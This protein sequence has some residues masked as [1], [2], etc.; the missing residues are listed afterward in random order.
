MKFTAKDL[1]KIF[2]KASTAVFAK[3]VEQAAQMQANTDTATF[4]GFEDD[5]ALLE[6]KAQSFTLDMITA[7]AM[8]IDRRGEGSASMED[9]FAKS[10][11]PQDAI[12]DLNDAYAELSRYYGAGDEHEARRQDECGKAVLNAFIDHLQN[13]RP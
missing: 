5:P 7:F 1:A 11:T 2:M 9:A 3:K 6:Q 8:M 4:G 12:R 13:M 10:A